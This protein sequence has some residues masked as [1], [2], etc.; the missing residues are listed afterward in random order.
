MNIINKGEKDEKELKCLTVE[1]LSAGKSNTRRGHGG[2]G[3]KD[4]NRHFKL[5]DR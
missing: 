3:R 4:G 1:L 2:A 5:S